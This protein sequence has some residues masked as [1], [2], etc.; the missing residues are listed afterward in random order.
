MKLW[1]G[2]TIS[3]LGSVVTWTAI[4]FVAILLLAAGPAELGILTASASVGTL[5]TGL[6]AGVQADRMRRRP[7]LIVTDLLR[8]LALFTIPLAFALGALRM[9][10]LYMVVFSAA[11]LGAFFDVAYRSYLPALVGRPRIVEGNAK[12]GT[13][14]A[15]AEVGAPG[16]AGA[17]VQVF[18]PVVAIVVDAVSFV[19]SAISILLIEHRE[20]RPKPPAARS[21]SREIGEGLSVVWSNLYLRATSGFNV[22]RYFFGSFIGVLYALYGLDDL[23]LSPFVVGV[24]ISLGGVGSLVGTALVTPTIRRFGIGATIV[25]VSLAGAALVFLL[26]LAKGQPP[27]V[28]AALLFVGQLLGDA[29]GTIED[30]AILSLR[31]QV[32]RDDLLGRVN[33]TAHVLTDGVAP[34]GALVG[35][36]LALAIGNQLTLL[37]AAV[38]ILLARAWLV[39]SPLGEMRDATTEP[40]AK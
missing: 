29:L 3:S 16:L 40:R 31:Q 37:V 39:F 10:L 36:A 26:P 14:E 33:A 19:V 34:L 15:V 7:I 4:Q 21:T 5:L 23:G 6:V 35:A 17:I 9:E 20:P 8:A 30:I 13:S 1:V 12:L 18:S 24:A 25:R 2:Q 32:T 11:V 38:G 28:A 22:Q 27:V